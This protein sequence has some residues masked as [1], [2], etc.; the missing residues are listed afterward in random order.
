MEAHDL[1]ASYGVVVEFP[2]LSICVSNKPVVSASDHAYDVGGLVV[3]GVKDLLLFDWINSDF[4]E[5]AS[6]GII[7]ILEF[8]PLDIAIA[9]SSDKEL[10]FLIEYNDF[11]ESIMKRSL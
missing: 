11:Y 10:F 8:P 3:G 7:N 4:E 9:A 6:L 5:I 1:L 2:D